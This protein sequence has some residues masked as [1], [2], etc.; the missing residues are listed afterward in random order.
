[1]QY[2]SQW[3]AVESIAH[4]IG[5]VPQILLEWVKRQEVDSGQRDGLSTG[6]PERFRAPERE[7]KGQRLARHEDEQIPQIQRVWH[8]NLQ[9]YGDD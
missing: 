7:A 1:M 8:A 3:A 9:L 2:A 6:E 4:K 5:F